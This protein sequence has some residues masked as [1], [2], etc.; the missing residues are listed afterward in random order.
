MLREGFPKQLATTFS[1]L[2]RQTFP[3]LTA[4]SAV[5]LSKPRGNSLILLGGYIEAHRAVLTWMLACCDGRG[6]Q[7]FPHFQHLKFWK[8]TCV[9]QSADIL[10]IEVLHTELSQRLDTIAKRQIHSDEIEAVY[11]LTPSG[12]PA[13]M[14]AAESIGRALLE[15]RLVARRA[16]EALRSNPKYEAFDRDLN[17][18]IQRFKKEYAESEEGKAVRAERQEARKAAK[19]RSQRHQNNPRNMTSDDVAQQLAVPV[20]AVRPG[21]DGTFSYTVSAEL[22]R[23]GRNGHGRYAALPLR[24]VGVTAEAFRPVDGLADR[25]RGRGRDVEK[26]DVS[27]TTE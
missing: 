16:Y 11:N 13:R 25:G 10:Q 12:H 7:P 18:A 21:D 20:E 19:K 14:Q 27:I 15:R 1:G 24:Q 26:A 6:M 4:I 2:C 8:Y 3:S 17:E 23:K 22:V 9:Q 5:D